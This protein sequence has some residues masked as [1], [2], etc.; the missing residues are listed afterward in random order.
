MRLLVAE[1]DRAVR[2]SLVRALSLEGY[3]VDAVKDGAEA[4]RSLAGDSP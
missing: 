1:D 3:D 4:L 2:T